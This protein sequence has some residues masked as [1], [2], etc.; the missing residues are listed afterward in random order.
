VIPPPPASTDRRALPTPGSYITSTDQAQVFN[1][2]VYVEDMH[3]ILL[4]D[5]SLLDQKQFNAHFAGLQFQMQPDGSKPTTN[6]WECFLESQIV[7]HP[8]SHGVCFVPALAPRE[9]VVRDGAILTNSW[10]PIRTPM[11]SGDV[12]PFL[13]H[14]KKLLPV[15]DDANILLAYMAAVVQYKGVKFQW[16]PFIQGVEGN[17]KSLISEVLEYCVGARYTHWPRAAMLG[18]QFNAAFYGKLLICVEDVKVSDNQASLWET[19]KPMITGTR[20][21]FEP[22]G[23]DSK[24]SR[25]FCANFMFNSNHQDGIRKT[26]NDRRICPFFCAQQSEADLIRCGM[27]EDYFDKHLRPWLFQQG[28]MAKLAGFLMAYDIPK[29]WNPAGSCIRAPRTSSTEAALKA[30]RGMV[31]QEVME[32]VEEGR[33]GFRGG[34]IASTAFDNL[35]AEIHMSRKIPRN[36]RGDILEGLGY[37]AH[38]GLPGGRLTA[39]LPDGTKPRLYSLPGICDGVRDPQVIAAAFIT[40]QAK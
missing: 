36:K 3:H 5:G 24:V 10:V 15:G 7:R 11:E 20:L 27:G 9:E 13:D 1:G 12:T 40:A 14:L 21:E 30:S 35:L 19:L 34:W 6:A 22:K 16:A 31:E 25:D 38:E 37:K 28:G 29:K 4:P 39:P 18:G 26:K 23:V 2:C 8:R 32:A 17:G 33:A